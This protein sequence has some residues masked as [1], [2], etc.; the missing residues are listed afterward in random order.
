MGGSKWVTLWKVNAD[1]T[2]TK[3][4]RITRKQQQKILEAQKRTQQLA[5]MTGMRRQPE[6]PVIK[7]KSF[8]DKI[9]E[10]QTDGELI[11][12]LNEKY[13]FVA[14]GVVTRND[15]DMVKRA[16]RTLDELE[17]QYPFMKGVISGLEFAVTPGSPAAMHAKFSS[18]EGLISQNFKFGEGWDIADNQEFYTGSERGHHPPNQTPESTVA[19]EFGHA[20]HNY[21]LGKKL[22]EAYQRSHIEAIMLIEDIK[23]GK[24]LAY[25]EKRAVESLGYKQP[26]AVRGK[27]SGYAKNAKSYRSNPTSES[28]AEAFADVYVNGDYASDVSKAY[29]KTLLDEARSFQ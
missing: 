9:N 25:L 3:V 19:H 8:R 5:G 16:T 14:P 10:A 18:K 27:I 7:V 4:G 6:A 21:I 22:N 15:R 20:I 1:G 26:A 2:R 23:H 12:T 17:E 11:T 28:F 13:S 29:V 24:A